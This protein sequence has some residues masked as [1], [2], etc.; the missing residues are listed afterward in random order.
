[1]DYDLQQAN[2]VNLNTIKYQNE[3]LDEQVKTI[4]KLRA[5]VDELEQ[6]NKDYKKCPQPL[7]KK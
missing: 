5:R 4:W 3:M 1:M 6:R 7:N 2:R